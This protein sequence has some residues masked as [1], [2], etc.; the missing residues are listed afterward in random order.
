MHEQY[1]A[2]AEH[3]MEYVNHFTITTFT[4]FLFY[5]KVVIPRL[6]LGPLNPRHKIC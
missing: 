3:F 5:K 1:V 2:L 6:G 4:T